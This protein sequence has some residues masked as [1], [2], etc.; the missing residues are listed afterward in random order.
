M[1]SLYVWSRLDK[2]HVHHR[3]VVAVTVAHCA[4]LDLVDEIG[5]AERMGIRC[6]IVMTGDARSPRRE[7]LADEGH[8][9]VLG[10]DCGNRFRGQGD[11]YRVFDVA[12]RAVAPI[13]AEAELREIMRRATEAEDG[14]LLGQILSGMDAM[15]H[16]LK[17]Y[18]HRR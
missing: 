12:D 13:A 9:V 15:D 14:V 18:G 7:D 1:T 11:T 17:A 10:N 3:K 2:M 16:V 6:R 8:A 5:M 4:G